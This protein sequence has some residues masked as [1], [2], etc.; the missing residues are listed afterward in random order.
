MPEANPHMAVD[1]IA[2][3]R[4]LV[5]EALEMADAARLHMLGIHLH[6]ALLNLSEI[7]ERAEAEQPSD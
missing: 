1:R 2:R 6:E 3:L 4:D 5:T 7:I